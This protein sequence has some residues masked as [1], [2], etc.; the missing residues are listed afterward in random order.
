M[1]KCEFHLF[2]DK[3]TKYVRARAYLVDKKIHP[4]L[5]YTAFKKGYR[6]KVVVN[7]HQCVVRSQESMVASICWA[8]IHES[9]H[10]AIRD[11]V[12]Y[13]PTGEERIVHKMSK[14]P[15]RFKRSKRARK[16]LSTKR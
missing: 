8:I 13:A 5:G 16:V 11:E 1:T 15:F 3:V 10:A 9:L 4:V 2:D 12:S 7:L 14:I 6:P